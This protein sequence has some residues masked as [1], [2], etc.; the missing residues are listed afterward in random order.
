VV[1][2]VLPALSLGEVVAST[3][4]NRRGLTDAAYR[5]WVGQAVYRHMSCCWGEVPAAV[6]ENNFASVLLGGHIVS[7]WPYENDALIIVQ[8]DAHMHTAVMLESEGAYDISGPSK[9]V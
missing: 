1:D 9:E 7:R 3:K 5:R 8:D 4:V 2:R 6:S